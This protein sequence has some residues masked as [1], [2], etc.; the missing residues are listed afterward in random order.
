MNLCIAAWTFRY[1][2]SSTALDR[3]LLLLGAVFKCMRIRELP[4]EDHSYMYVAE[5][6]PEGY[7]K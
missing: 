6:Y 1:D 3:S 4:R 5:L 2:A 7:K